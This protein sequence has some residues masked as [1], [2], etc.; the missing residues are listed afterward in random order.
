MKHHQTQYIKKKTIEVS[1]EELKTIKSVFRSI[2]KLCH[3]NKTKNIYRN[4]L[5]E[6]AQFAYEINDLLILYKITKKLNIEVEINLST[7]FL[8]EKIVS[9]KKK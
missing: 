7:I 9:D 6:E 8:L 1:D 3:P 2:A 5:Y 4:K